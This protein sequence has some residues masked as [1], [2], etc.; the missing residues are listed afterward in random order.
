MDAGVR[1]GRKVNNSVFKATDTNGFGIFANPNLIV[2]PHPIRIWLATRVNQPFRT[3]AW[4]SDT[5]DDSRTQRLVL[6]QSAHPVASDTVGERTTDVDPELPNIHPVVSC[7]VVE[8]GGDPA[9]ETCLARFVVIGRNRR[10]CQTDTTPDRFDNTS[11][12]SSR[13]SK[14]GTC[15]KSLM[16]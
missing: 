7:A 6:K 2:I 10:G 15:R 16:A 4:T 3:G 13:R 12:D 9:I 8:S 1:H 11:G 14:V 5:L